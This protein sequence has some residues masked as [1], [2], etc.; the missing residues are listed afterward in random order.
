MILWSRDYPQG[1][2]LESGF[3]KLAWSDEDCHK[4]WKMFCEAWR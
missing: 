2:W 3:S 4:G 1:C